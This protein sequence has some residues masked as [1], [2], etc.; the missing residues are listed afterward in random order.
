MPPERA[1]SAQ[2]T[3]QITASSVAGLIAILAFFVLTTINESDRRQG[4]YGI[5]DSTAARSNPFLVRYS[6][7][8]VGYTGYEDFVE[9]D[10]D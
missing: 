4:T 7:F 6:P 10:D 2:R 1:D 9:R 8:T 3:W 5:A